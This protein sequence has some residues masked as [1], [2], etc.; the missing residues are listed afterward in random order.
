MNTDDT[1][2]M[3]FMILLIIGASALAAYAILWI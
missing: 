2:D 3:A 1:Q